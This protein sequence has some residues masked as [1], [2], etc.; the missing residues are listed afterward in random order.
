M[1]GHAGPANPLTAAA[2][3]ARDSGD[4]RALLSYLRL[5]RTA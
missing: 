3:H 4:R 2:D 5:R 1:S